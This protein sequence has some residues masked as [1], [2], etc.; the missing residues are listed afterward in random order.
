MARPRNMAAALSLLYDLIDG[1]WAL[2]GDQSSDASWYT[3]RLALQAVYSA[4]ELYMLTDK[5]PGHQDT[6]SALE[7]RMQDVERAGQGVQ[8]A[9]T[10]AMELINRVKMFG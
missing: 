1:I 3:K 6:W 5:S 2:C 10:A 8:T 9:Q 4:T 7:R